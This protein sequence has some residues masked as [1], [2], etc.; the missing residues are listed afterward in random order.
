MS[1]FTVQTIETLILHID[2]L[3][4]EIGHSSIQN[5]NIQGCEKLWIPLIFNSCYVPL[6]Q[7]RLGKLFEFGPNQRLVNWP[8]GSG[9]PLVNIT[10]TW[11]GLMLTFWAI[12][13][14]ATSKEDDAVGRV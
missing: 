10:V 7:E 2:N 9:R 1:H 13:T 8:A 12:H 14:G 5:E 4:Y 11:T 6:T 3:F